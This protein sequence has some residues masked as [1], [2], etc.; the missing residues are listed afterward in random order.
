MSTA[1]RNSETT[2]LLSPLLQQGPRSPSQ[3]SATSTAAEEES[4]HPF[5]FSLSDFLRFVGPGFMVGVGYLDPG[6]WATD[7]AAGS[8]FSYSLLYII[9]IANI[10]AVL[11]QYL[12]IKLGTVT[13]LDLAAA[14]R[15]HFSPAFNIFLFIICELAIIA[16]DL[17]EVIGTAIALNMLFGLPL[18]WGVAVTSLDVLV[19]LYMYGARYVKMYEAAVM[20]L[21]GVV[22]CCFL[23]LLA[24]SGPA[25]GQVAWGFIPST[26]VFRTEGQLYIAMAIIGATIMPHNLYLHSSL[27][28]HRAHVSSTVLGE[29]TA[30]SSGL[31]AVVA[32]SASATEL[33]PNLPQPYVRKSLIPKSLFY[34]N[35]DS[36][37]ALTIAV[38][39]NASILI[40]AGAS[41][42]DPENPKEVADLVDAYHLLNA[43]LGFVPATLF[44]IALFCAGQS[45]TITATMAGQIV[46]EGFLGDRVV[47]SAVGQRLGTRMLAIVP[48]MIAAVWSGEAGMGALIIGSQVV[49]SFQLPFAIW[50]LVWITGGGGADVGAGRQRNA[51]K[52]QF[53]VG[54]AEVEDGE[55]SIVVIDYRNSYWTQRLFEFR[56]K[57]GEKMEE[58]K[59]K[60]S[61]LMLSEDS[62]R[63]ET[64]AMQVDGDEIDKD[65][66][67]EQQEQVVAEEIAE[68][69][70]TA[71]EKAKRAEEYKVQANAQY[72]TGNYTGAVELYSKAI[73]I[74]PL[75][76][77][78]L[79]NR[80]AALTMQRKH[81]T[82]LRDC[83][84]ALAIDG[85]QT[86]VRVR[87]AKALVFQADTDAALALLADASHDSA[88]KALANEITKIALLL[89][90]AKTALD[91]A[92]TQQQTAD[93]DRL[94]LKALANVESAIS[95]ADPQNASLKPS[96]SSSSKLVLADLGNIAHKWLVLRADILI[97]LVDLPEASK[98][99]ANQILSYDP[100]NSEALAL[101]AVVLYLNDSHSLDHVVKVLANA[102]TYDPD[103]KRARVFLKKIKS[104]E[105]AKKEGN[106]A[107]GAANWELAESKYN[108]WLQDDTVGGVVR[109]KVLS[110]RAMVFSKIGR[111]TAC[112][113][114]CKAAIDLLTRL[115]FPS[116]LN[117]SSNAD[118]SNSDLAS[119]THSS[120]FL[121]LHLRRADSYLKQESYEDAVR[122]YTVA[123]EIKP[124]DR[125]IT[126]ALARAKQAEKAAKRK[127]YYK[128]LGVD[129]SADDGAIKKAYRKLALLYHP[130]KQAS[131]PEEERASCDT[132][133]KEV[134]EA[135]SVLSDPQKKQMFDSGM[136]IDGSSASAGSGGMGNPF[137][138]FGGGMDQE[139]ILRMFMGAQG[140]S[141]FGGGQQRRGGNGAG[142][143]NSYGG[144]SHGGHSFHFG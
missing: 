109:V 82:A 94:L 35:I 133:F 138:G 68:V 76:S 45:S 57:H 121:K 44:A 81:A 143:G 60:K 78:Y 100:T 69:E 96:P 114:D 140:G 126:N 6:N 91:Q 55:S 54:E 47:F 50:P 141:G 41:F 120:L 123:A 95:L 107:Y 2:P 51:M 53:E 18:V 71:E 30:V 130:D 20:T 75:S 117:N 29:I 104:L 85:S 4:K 33:I 83:Q 17:A 132:K 93:R 125:E 101:R 1:Y 116:N 124:N 15:V 66:G 67:N 37:V 61:L 58:Q 25:W 87:A 39:I 62:E 98:S 112:I 128:I 56:L 59:K 106:E 144:H 49:L 135:Y 31:A 48:A 14:C 111:H 5:R 102:L 26:G 22:A 52:I 32:D 72:K 28:Q 42:H 65:D 80:S 21:I 86:K 92:Q 40:V 110:N 113:N 3:L 10:M 73:E 88:T 12:C 36:V 38:L 70:D 27:V 105:A 79:A 118:P 63:D 74:V 43:Q 119:S 16:C 90:D 115:S 8:Q 139:D 46:T 9:L 97:Q 127:D 137:G 134:S 136:D 84:A 99:I 24:V 108:A 103:N 89:K 34:S 131:L 64:N 142:F 122:D 19:V 7:L 129:R 13:G 23:Y 77:T 11:L